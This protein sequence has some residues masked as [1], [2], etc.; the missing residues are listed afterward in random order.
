MPSVII[1]PR[2]GIEDDEFGGI[3]YI[4]GRVGFIKG[5]AADGS[6]S[7]RAKVSASETSGLQA[8]GVAGSEGKIVEPDHSP[9]NS[10]PWVFTKIVTEGSAMKATKG[11]GDNDRSDDVH[12]I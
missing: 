12:T 10:D 5:Y 8:T 11:M 4:Y 9:V 6:G 2:I 1:T 3:A 7:L